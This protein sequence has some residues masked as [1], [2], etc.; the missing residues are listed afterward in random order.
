MDQ[1]GQSC[2]AKTEHK[3]DA[4]GRK[5]EQSLMY[6]WWFSAYGWVKPLACPGKRKKERKILEEIQGGTLGFFKPLLAEGKRGL[7]V[8]LQ[9][10]L[11]PEGQEVRTITNIFTRYHLSCFC[12]KDQIKFES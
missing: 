2:D 9:F 4:C 11:L 10:S 3:R 6:L 8:V 5:S 12:A 1:V 7:F